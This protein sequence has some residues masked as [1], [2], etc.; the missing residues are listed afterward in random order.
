MQLNQIFEV[1]NTIDILANHGFAKKS[2]TRRTA[3]TQEVKEKRNSEAFPF[4]PSD[5]DAII[6]THSHVDHSGPLPLI[7]RAGFSGSIYTHE[8][9]SDFCKV[10]PKDAGY[11]TRKRNISTRPVVILSCRLK[12]TIHIALRSL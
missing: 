10:L 11:L 1:E 12:L 8:A 9:S 6:L 3:I 5:I 7:A 4:A 2:L